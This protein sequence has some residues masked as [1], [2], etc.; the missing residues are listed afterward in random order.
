MRGTAVILCSF[1]I[2]MDENRTFRL[3]VTV[4]DQTTILTEDPLAAMHW[5]NIRF[6][7]VSEL[8]IPEVREHENG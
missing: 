4:G 8:N 2:S 1:E 7:S 3:S 6:L 5:T